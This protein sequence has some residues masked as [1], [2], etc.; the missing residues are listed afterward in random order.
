[1]VIGYFLLVALATP[2]PFVTKRV[3]QVS[4]PYGFAPSTLSRMLSEWL[5]NS[6]AYMH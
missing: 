6:G 2:T 4:I 1:M 5:L 3:P